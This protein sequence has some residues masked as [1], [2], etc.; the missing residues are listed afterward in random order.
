MQIDFLG[1][2]PCKKPNL[3]RNGQRWSQAEDSALVEFVALHRDEQPNSD[4]WPAM[5]ESNPYWEKAA[6]YVAG[7]AKCIERTGK[8]NLKK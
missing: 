8:F 1:S 3:V 2:P 7:R 4:K 6:S 5:R